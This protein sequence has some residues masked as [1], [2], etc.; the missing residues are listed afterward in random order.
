MVSPD[1]K[2]AA[3]EITIPSLHSH[4]EA[5]CCHQT[6]QDCDSTVVAE[7]N[8]RKKKKSLGNSGKVAVETNLTAMPE[9]KRGRVSRTHIRQFYKMWRKRS[10]NRG[11]F[12]WDILAKKFQNNDVPWEVKV[13]FWRLYYGGSTTIAR[14]SNFGGYYCNAVCDSSTPLKSTIGHYVYSSN[15]NNAENTLSNQN[16]LKEY[17]MKGD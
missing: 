12:S 11:N 3:A 17:N 4:K 16:L 2:E 15:K 8:D 1:Q 6:M 10:K 14:S 13:G 7:N 5:I 9:I